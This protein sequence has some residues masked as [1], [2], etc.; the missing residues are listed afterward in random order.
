MMFMNTENQGEASPSQA[1]VNSGDDSGN[2]SSG[3]AAAI[4]FTEKPAPVPVVAEEVPS[5][6]PATDT[7][8]ETP[9]PESE[10]TEDIPSEKPET[11]PEDDGVLS[12]KSSLDPKLR[13]KIQQRVNQEISKRKALED[14]IAV[15]EAALQQSQAAKV[16]ATKAQTAQSSD[17]KAIPLSNLQSI[18]AV[19]QHAKQAQEAIDW[20]QDH[21]SSEDLGDGIVHNGE[22]FDRSRL[23]GIVKTATNALR[24]DVPSRKAFLISRKESGQQ[25]LAMFPSMGDKNS[26]DYHMAVA[27]YRSNPWL[28]NIAHS[29][30]V[31]G[32][33]IE[34]IKALRAKASLAEAKSAK[35]KPKAVT[36]KPSSDQT[37]V[38][39]GSSIGRISGTASASNAFKAIQ[40]KMMSKG[41]I[42]AVEAA[43]LLQRSAQL[44]KN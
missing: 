19:D 31:V 18:E 21:L 15:M 41:A 12:Q 32:L 24:I 23:R 35:P 6:D 38:S 29:D 37:A 9:P 5:A 33:Q 16:E 43:M 14:R 11:A 28:Q 2:L 42:T 8:T 30:I 26:E 22:T 17:S 34:G 3:Q 27:A 10:L 39:S 4:L 20:A 44:R 40:E 7:S 25:A 13:E 36:A 1:T